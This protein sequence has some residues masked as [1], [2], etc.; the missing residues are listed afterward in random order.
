[1]SLTPVCQICQKPIT[2]HR[3]NMLRVA[4]WTANHHKRGNLIII[5]PE[6]L[7]GTAHAVCVL[8]QQATIPEQA[9]LI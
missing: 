8:G 7:P 9:Q 6:R 3:G 5:D 1:M 2:S 4:G